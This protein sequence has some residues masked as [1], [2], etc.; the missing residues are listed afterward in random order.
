MSRCKHKFVGAVEYLGGG[1]CCYDEI[2]I[3]FGSSF[4]TSER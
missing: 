2:S 4:V 3:F 1:R